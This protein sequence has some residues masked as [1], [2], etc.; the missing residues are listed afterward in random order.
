MK[1]PPLLVVADRG[2][3]KTFI[4]NGDHDGSIPHLADV[5][6]IDEAHHRYQ[7]VYTDQAGSFAKRGTGHVG[8][9]TA[10]RMKVDTEKNTRIVKLI[11]EHL[12]ELLDL[13]RPRRWGFAAPSEINSAILSQLPEAWT[14]NLQINLTKDLV[15]EDAASLR[16]HFL[17]AQA[18]G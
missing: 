10:E 15:K 18:R 2:Q 7:D 13:H 11:G 16:T 4:S 3:I 5:I 12:Q 9:A 14:E 17:S 8:N 1:T 6:R